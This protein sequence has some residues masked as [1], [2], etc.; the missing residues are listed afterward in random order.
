MSDFTVD[1]RTET[2]VAR[3]TSARN[4]REVAAISARRQGLPVGVWGMAMVVA[5]EVTLFGTFV[6]SYF[7]LR[8][9]AAHWP[10]SGIPR[11]ELLTP[12][13]LAGALATTAAPM[14]L[15]ARAASVG[16][17]GLVRA[18]VATALLVQC[19][20]FGYAAHDFRQQLRV[21]TPSTNAYGSLYY[22]L[23]GADHAHVFLGLLLDLWLLGKLATGLTSYRAT[24]TR[25]VALYWHAVIAITLVVTGTLLSAAA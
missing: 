23:L 13:V 8:F 6:G 24:A 18:L 19:G 10:P 7:Y 11:P 14:E 9:N 17:V 12:L 1:R 15:A 2:L 4:G 22:V 16:R 5:S 20:Y 21:F 3:T 25:V